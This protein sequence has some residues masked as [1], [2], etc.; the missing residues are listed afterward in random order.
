MYSQLLKIYFELWRICREP[1][2]LFE[3]LVLSYETD[4]MPQV[5]S[6]ELITVASYSN[7]GALSIS[8]NDGYDIHLSLCAR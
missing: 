6:I 1:T 7:E 3:F 2:D 5:S 8:L 4:C